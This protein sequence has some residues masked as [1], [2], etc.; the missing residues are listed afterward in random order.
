MIR[1]EKRNSQRGL[2]RDMQL[3]RN[4]G[5]ARGPTRLTNPLRHVQCLAARTPA[6]YHQTLPHCIL[7][8]FSLLLLFEGT[9]LRILP[10]PLSAIPPT[11]SSFA[12]FSPSCLL[13]FLPIH[14]SCLPSECIPFHLFSFLSSIIHPPPSIHLPSF[15]VPFSFVIS[16]MYTSPTF[17]HLLLLLPADTREGPFSYFFTRLHCGHLRMNTSGI[18]L[19]SLPPNHTNVTLSFSYGQFVN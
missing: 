16:S 15:L 19:L 14:P 8:L 6:S 18:S 9:P 5:N 13:I 3:S 17:L 11:F 10:F 12:A 7:L 2:A 4:R 1:R